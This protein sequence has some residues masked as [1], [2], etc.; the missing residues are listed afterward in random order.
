MDEAAIFDL[1]LLCLGSPENAG[2][3]SQVRPLL[4]PG[5]HKGEASNSDSV[6]LCLRIC[7]PLFGDPQGRNRSVA[8]PPFLGPPRRRG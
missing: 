6:P 5:E 3:T 2:V 1:A 4:H 8:L 7:A